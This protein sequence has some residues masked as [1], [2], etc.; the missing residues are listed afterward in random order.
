MAEA[1]QTID[2]SGDLSILSNGALVTVESTGLLTCPTDHSLVDIEAERIVMTNLGQILTEGRSWQPGIALMGDEI[3]LTNVGTISAGI[4]V[5]GGQVDFRNEG[6]ISG[7]VWLGG[8]V[9]V[10]NTGIM[11]DADLGS[12]RVEVTNAGQMGWV[13]LSGGDDIY[14]E[15]GQGRADMLFA[16]SGDDLILGGRSYSYMWGDEGCDTLAGGGGGDWLFGGTDNDVLRS[17]GDGF[18]LLSG[19]EGDDLV[20][21]GRGGH[22]HLFG[23]MGQD[24]LR[25]GDGQDDLSGGGGRDWLNGGEG[26]D[27]IEG[28]WGSDTL[29]GGAGADLFLFTQRSSGED[30][31]RDFHQ[32]EDLIRLGRELHLVTGFSGQA[33]EVRIADANRIEGDRDGD[34]QADWAVTFLGVGAL[35]L[36]DFG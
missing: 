36:S 26:N 12:E 1:S 23:G 5:H 4:T 28:G 24:T 27:T 31:V 34:G 22:D 32:G 11:G 25:G 9:I 15:V 14:R 16:S 20:S 17:W 10:V 33:G 13:L 8:T 3:L 6:T 18:S 35:A 29:S 2:A 7:E 30:R 21:S 19:D